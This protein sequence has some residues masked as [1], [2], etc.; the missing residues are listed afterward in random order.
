MRIEG[1]PPLFHVLVKLLCSVLP[2]PLALMAAGSLGLSVLLF[3]T[4]RLL[5]S[6]SGSPRY[7]ARATLVF[8]LTYAYAWELGAMVRQYT[9]GL[10]LGLLSF[11]Y[12]RDAL[13]RRDDRSS[14]LA[15]TLAGTLCALSSAHAA[16]VAGAGFLA[17]GVLS[18]LG[19]R[20]WRSWSPILLSL[21]TFALV[22]YL[23]SPF[24]E[25]VAS[26]NQ[27]VHN[28][29]VGT[30]ILGLQVLVGSVMPSDW[31]LVE[32][33][34]PSWLYQTYALLRGFGFWGLVVG[35]VVALAARGR[36]IRARRGLEAFDLIAGLA[37]IPPLL[38]V[39]LH[40]YF[41]QYR[42]HLFLGMPLVVIVVGWGLDRRPVGFF[43]EEAR[44]IGLWAFAPWFGFQILLA[45]GSFKLEVPCS[46]SD[47]KKG[48]QVL[49]PNAHVVAEVDW[50]A[51]AMM[52][53]RPDIQM[54]C[55][56]W[57]VLPFRYISPDAEWRKTVPL[58]PIVVEECA[59][60]PDRV[61]YAGGGAGSAR[62]SRAPPRCR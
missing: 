27:T 44:R 10:G 24:P 59:A 2:A 35:M 7:S 8:A 61:F 21:P 18:V 48:S 47:G 58:P 29:P 37:A 17:F 56:A 42:H 5:A 36:R 45:L 23:A 32:A 57:R 31:W 19:R 12:L 38:E 20:P 26:A 51:A 54:R 60:A 6:V 49:A 28:T 4:Y 41:G 14:M 33:S 22:A 34:S 16:C 52:F 55:P 1:V 46:F 3:G 25:R 43:T 40:H 13:R 53:W 9:L 39:T 62:S 50:R 30:L 11:S 15:G